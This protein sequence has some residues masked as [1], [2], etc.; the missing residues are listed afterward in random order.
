MSKHM[1]KDPRVVSIVVSTIIGE[2]AQHLY[3]PRYCQWLD[4]SRGD[5]LYAPIVCTPEF[6][7][8]VVEVQLTLDPS[9]IRRLTTYCWNASDAYQV[10]PIAV[11]FCIQAARSEISD[12][13]GDTDKAPFMRTLPCDFWAQQHFVMTATTIHDHINTTPMHPLVALV[14][15]LTQQQTCLISLE[16]KDDDTVQL[17][18]KIAK[19]AMKDKIEPQDRSV[20]V[21]LDV[22]TQVKKQFQKIVDEVNEEGELD[23]NRIKAY[24]A[25][26]ALYSESCIRKYQGPTSPSSSMPAPPDLPENVTPTRSSQ[27][28]DRSRTIPAEPRKGDMDVVVE[29]IDKRKR[30]NKRMD[31]LQCYREGRAKGYFTKYKNHQSLKASFNSRKIR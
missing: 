26:G 9:F 3:A 11:T 18:Y 13:F 23:P 10:K 19:D 16:H 5:V 4:G 1:L 14:Y 27:T 25:D 31:W 22:C 15:V 30:L 20:D 17:L 8:L 12:K 29:F 6:P 21:L 7:P 2:S 24:A 28:V